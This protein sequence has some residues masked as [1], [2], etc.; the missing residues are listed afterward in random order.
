MRHERVLFTVPLGT[1][2]L[3]VRLEGEDAG[4]SPDPG[5]TQS[6]LLMCVANAD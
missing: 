4:C 2:E 5:I 1:Q 6:P 3:L